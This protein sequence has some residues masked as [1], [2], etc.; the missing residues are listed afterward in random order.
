MEK[1]SDKMTRELTPE[2]LENVSGGISPALVEQTANAVAALNAPA[3]QNAANFTA[4]YTPV[5]HVSPVT[6]GT[7]PVPACDRRYPVKFYTGK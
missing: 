1:K 5:V 6:E 4:N 2:E 7:V 3:A